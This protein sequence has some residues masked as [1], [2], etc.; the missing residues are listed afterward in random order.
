VA[1][2]GRRRAGSG[3]GVLASEAT[4]GTSPLMSHTPPA[5]LPADPN[6]ADIF[7]RELQ[8]AVTDQPRS[9]VGAGRWPSTWPP[10]HTGGVRPRAYLI[11]PATAAVTAR[12]TDDFSG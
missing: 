7:L 6:Q 12:A 10:P 3:S 1:L 5:L 2:P 4:H 9:A 8:N 11:T